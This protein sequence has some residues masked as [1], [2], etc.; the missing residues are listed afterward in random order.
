MNRQVQRQKS[1]SLV[2]YFPKNF[3]FDGTAY[4][5]TRVNELFALTCSGDKR[6]KKKPGKNTE[7]SYHAPPSGLE[8]ETL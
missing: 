8:P 2:P 6:L 4:P 3:T 5:T 1:G 7:Q